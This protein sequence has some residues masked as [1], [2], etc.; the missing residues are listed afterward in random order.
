MYVCVCVCVR[1]EDNH[2]DSVS[3]APHVCMEQVS[4]EKNYGP[5]PELS[6]HQGGAEM[7][8]SM[9]M[10]VARMSGLLVYSLTLLCLV[11]ATQG[12]S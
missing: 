7:V 9:T 8:S 1:D 3:L 4:P 6:T 5:S 2:C 10:T 12:K 11:S